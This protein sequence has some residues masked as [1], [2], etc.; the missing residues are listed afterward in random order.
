MTPRRPRATILHLATDLLQFLGCT[1]L[2]A[3][4]VAALVTV[5]RIS[6]FCLD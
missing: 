4:C 1:I 5:A 2:F 3:A 6:F